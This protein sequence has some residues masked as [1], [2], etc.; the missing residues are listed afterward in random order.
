MEEAETVDPALD[1]HVPWPLRPGGIWKSARV[2]SRRALAVPSRQKT[3]NNFK[4]SLL[5]SLVVWGP[6]T[7][8]GYHLSLS[9]SDRPMLVPDIGYW[10]RV[11]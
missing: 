4:R 6:K 3:K 5:I 2:A 8:V 11:K 7:N 9:D 10:G 1:F